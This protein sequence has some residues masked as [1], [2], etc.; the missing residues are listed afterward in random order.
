MKQADNVYIVTGPMFTPS[1][2]PNGGLKMEYKMIGKFPE[3]VAVPTHYYKVILA[4][5]T[6]SRGN[7]TSAVGAFVLPNA[8]IDPKTPLLSFAMPVE[9][10][11]S[12]TG[13]KFFPGYLS[14]A[15]RIAVDTSAQGEQCCFFSWNI[16]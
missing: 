4:E 1:M 14:D 8:P 13:V 6:D 11:E 10:V 5:T 2:D 9:V 12:V 16:G 15:R 3:P 7:K